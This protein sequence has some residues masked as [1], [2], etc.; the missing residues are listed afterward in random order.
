MHQHKN[1]RHRP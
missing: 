1:S